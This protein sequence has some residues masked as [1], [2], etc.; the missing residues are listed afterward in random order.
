M[1]N[2]LL[3]KLIKA[4]AGRIRF[5]MAVV[6][7]SVSLLLIFSSVQLEADYDDMLNS[8]N[9]KDSVANFLVINKE[10]TGG[11][12]S[13]TLTDA[14]IADL[15]SQPFV[16]QTGTL[17]P[18]RFKVSAQGASNSIP[19]ST[20]FFFESVADDFIDVQSTNWKWDANSTYIP[21][22]VPN[23]F[24]TMYN[25]G[26]A[27]SQGL[28]QLSAELVKSLPVQI[29]ITSA[30]ET[31]NY[32]GKV[33]GFSDRISSV[34]VPQPFMT[35][36][37]AKFGTNQNA[38]PSRL[39]IKTKDPGDPVL[40]A[41]LKSHGL[42]TDADKTRF[43]KLRKTVDV[44]VGVS[45]VTGAVMLLF[46]LLIFTL[47]IQLTIASAKDEISLLITLGAAPKQLHRFLMGQFFPSNIIIIGVTLALVAGL[48]FLLQQV[49]HNQNI[50]LS[51]LISMFTIL[52]GIIMLLVLWVVNFT[53]IKKYVAGQR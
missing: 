49:L 13:T 27:P 31:A 7:L 26:F 48:Q 46:A 11:Q 8:K 14:E 21:M 23:M 9:N 51:P 22:I 40:T 6:G 43:S 32:F 24:L 44:V 28:P 15:K 25:F 39:I 36:A 33:V 18:G 2:I 42:T 10:V 53:T 35:W 29:S 16:E 38:K 37:N 5:V 52:A 41:Y 30:G 34:L 12:A 50:Y 20:D 19:F 3:K 4:G 1:L 47:F 45:W 17:T